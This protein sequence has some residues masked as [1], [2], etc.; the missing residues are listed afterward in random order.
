MNREAQREDR[1]SA[2]RRRVY[3][4]APAGKVEWWNETTP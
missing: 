2:C 3:P 4:R 1:K